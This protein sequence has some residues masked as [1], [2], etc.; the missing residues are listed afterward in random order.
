[1]FSQ[2][3]GFDSSVLSQKPVELGSLWLR[4]LLRFLLMCM[5]RLLLLL[6]VLSLKK[7]LWLKSPPAVNKACEERKTKRFV[8]YRSGILLPY[9]LWTRIKEILSL[10]IWQTHFIFWVLMWIKS[11]TALPGISFMYRTGP[12]GKLKNTNNSLNDTIYQL[13]F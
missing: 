11:A 4:L 5:F 3:F 2:K 12:T 7:F 9:K 10:R 13:S 8:I 1:M 6:K